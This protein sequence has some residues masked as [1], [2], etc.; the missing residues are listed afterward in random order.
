VS[1][2]CEDDC[3]GADEEDVSDDE[4]ADLIAELVF[5]VNVFS[6]SVCAGNMQANTIV[7]IKGAITAAIV[8]D[9]LM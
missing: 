6:L 3:A 1:V 4:V 9:F 8:V 5:V 7:I 2:V